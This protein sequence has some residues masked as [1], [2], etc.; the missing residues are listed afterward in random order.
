MII[1]GKTLVS[2]ELFSE[3]FTC[4][5]AACK[6]ACCVEGSSG[7]PLEDEELQILEDIYDEVRPYLRP[8]G[9]AAIEQQGFFIVDQDGDFTTPLVDDAECAYVVFDDSGT[10]KCGIEQAYRD[11]KV[12][13]AKPISCHLY[14]IRIKELKDFDA[15]NYHKWHICEPACA[16][17]ARFKMPVFRFCKS[18]LI[19]KYGEAYYNELEAAYALIEKGEMPS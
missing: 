13:W 3:Q 4:D 7:A 18:S 2:D 10:A 15:L 6:G 16:C 12:N 8:E 1:I 5:L 19:R 11:G 9:I 14:P 17:G